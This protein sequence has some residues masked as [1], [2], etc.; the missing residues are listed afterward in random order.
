MNV[1]LICTGNT[2]R[3]AMAD[4]LLREMA[5]I[6]GLQIQVQSAGVAAYP[7]EPASKGATEAL[8]KRG[9]KAH[10]HRSQTFT[11]E[12]ANWAH[13]ILT[14][15]RSHKEQIVRQYPSVSDRI[16]TLKEYISDSETA[17]LDIEDPY[18]GNSIVFESCASEIQQ[19]LDKLIKKLHKEEI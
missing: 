15:T 10:Q 2:C 17:D 5:E 14:M 19:S 8:A 18:G 6:Q 7:G 3:S 12:L 11:L 16:F 13:L 9:I 1:L 4:L